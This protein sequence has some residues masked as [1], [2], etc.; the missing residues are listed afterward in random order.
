MRSGVN[1]NGSHRSKV[2]SLK[3]L[4]TCR[5]GLFSYLTQ[6][7]INKD[8]AE[9]PGPEAW[10][11]EMLQEVLGLPWFLTGTH[12]FSCRQSSKYFVNLCCSPEP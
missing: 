10:G 4:L 9:L 7:S 12:L 3:V 6:T 8:N 11:R 1:G 5:R 2:L